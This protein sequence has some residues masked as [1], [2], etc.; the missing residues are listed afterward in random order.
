[1]ARPRGQADPQSQKSLPYLTA[2]APNLLTYPEQEAA[3]SEQRP[4]P[5]TKG[6]GFD[7]DRAA[8]KVS[9]EKVAA[10]VQAVRREHPY[11]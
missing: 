1:M 9:P 6:G 11:G 3:S 2:N 5:F 7:A 4:D 10:A 8:G